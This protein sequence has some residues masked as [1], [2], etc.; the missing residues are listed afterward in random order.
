MCK[1]LEVMEIIKKIKM[2]GCENEI[3][4]YLVNDRINA[5]ANI[6]TQLAEKTNII[7]VIRKI[8]RGKDECI[9]GL[10]E[11]DKELKRHK[12][13]LEGIKNILENY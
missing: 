3:L 4:K 8:N 12:L 9:A 7:T 2:T 5:L 11:P 1:E 13:N 10:C 6:K